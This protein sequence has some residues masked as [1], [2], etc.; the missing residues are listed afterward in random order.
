MEVC[1]AKG[2]HLW[3]E[4]FPE[5]R[6]HIRYFKKPCRLFKDPSPFFLGFHCGSICKIFPV[7]PVI[8][9][10]PWQD[11]HVMG[12]EYPEPQ[13]V[14][15]HVAATGIKAPFFPDNLSAKEHGRG[16]DKV[17][18]KELEEKI[19]T[20]RGDIGKPLFHGLVFNGIPLGVNQGLKSTD[21][22]KVPVGFKKVHLNE[23]LFRVKHVVRGQKAK[24]VTLGHLKGLVERG[25][26]AHVFLM[27]YLYPFMVG[28]LVTY[29]AGFVRGAVV[30][31]DKLPVLINLG[32]NAL[33]C[34]FNVS[35]MVIGRNYN[36]HQGVRCGGIHFLFPLALI[37]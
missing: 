16:R 26:K 36:G 5:L 18:F 2:D 8:D 25:A 6:I 10:G 15:L 3:P 11:L 14:I 27:N 21:S 12:L 19:W 17:S 7:P 30:Y 1:S 37:L 20:G 34:I 32:K 4:L 33:Y 31:Y 29:L 35:F 28:E 13:V 9:Q 24:I 23:K 22:G